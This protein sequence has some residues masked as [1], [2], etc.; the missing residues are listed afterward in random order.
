MHTSQSILALSEITLLMEI[1][2][3]GIIE[4]KLIP[5]FTPY[6]IFTAR[7]NPCITQLMHKAYK[8]LLDKL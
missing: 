3:L 7:Y 8:N 4:T 5:H 2:V 1:Y 6:F